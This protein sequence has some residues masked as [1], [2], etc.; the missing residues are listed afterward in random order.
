MMM[1]TLAVNRT[2]RYTNSLT[3]M[4]AKYCKV[5]LYIFFEMFS[6]LKMS[7]AVIGVPAAKVAY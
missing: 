1:V 4:A 5:K 6:K 7:I 3:N 2:S